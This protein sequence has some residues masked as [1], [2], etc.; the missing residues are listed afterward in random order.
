V[1]YS[2]NFKGY[3]IYVAGEREVEISHDVTFNRDIA[4][5]K[6]NNLPIPRKDNEA[7][8]KKQGAK[9]DETISDIDEPMDPIDSPPQESSSF[10][11]RPSWLRET[12]EDAE[13]HISPRGTFCESKKPNRYQGYLN[14]MSIIIQNEPSSFEEFVKQQ[15][16]KDAMN[17]EYKS[18]MK[19]DVWDVVPRPQDKLVVT[20]RWLYKIKH[21]DDGNAKKFK[22]HFVA[23][24]FSQK[25]EVDHDEI[26]ALVSR[27]T[28]IHLRFMI[29]NLM[30][31]G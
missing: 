10:K 6:I 15:V 2:E 17:E 26:F 23:Q 7:N 20:S 19:N 8:I 31:A 14:V 13:R 4:L 1:G 24:G 12:L 28:T 27:Y 21:G 18:I 29:G 5:N 22:A 9:E 30:Y 25:E 3:R 11:R 16:W